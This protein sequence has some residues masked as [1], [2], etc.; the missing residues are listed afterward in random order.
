MTNALA[1]AQGGSLNT[2]FRNRII[3]GDMRIDQRNA[4]AS[5]TLGTVNPQYLLDRWGFQTSQSSKLTVKQNLNSVTPPAGF[6][7]YM[8]V[9]VAATATV[10][11]GD[12]F[13]VR[14]IVEG[15]NAA[16]LNWGTANAKPITI[17]FLVYSSLT[18][19]FGACV[20]NW[21]FNRSY[22]FTYNIAAANTWTQISVTIPGDTSG[23]WPTDNTGGLTLTFGLG[24]GSTFLGTAGVWTASGCLSATGSVNMLSTLGATWYI[25]GVQLEKGSAATPFEFRPYGTELALCQ[26]YFQ[27][28]YQYDTVG[29]TSTFTGASF[30]GAGTQ[31]AALTTGYM[32]EREPF[33]VRMRTS[34]TVTGWDTSGNLGKC[35]RFNPNTANNTNESANFAGTERYVNCTSSSGSSASTLGFHWYCSAEL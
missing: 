3:N 28:S 31:G 30:I 32:E 5:V 14:Q 22:P 29:G 24:I 2:T 21:T 26:R 27:K 6:S 13:S 17:S 35:T 16:D 8:G 15:Y 19:T 1:L 12:Y 7:N 10:G 11:S 9:S 23:T 25:T 33:P 18:G 20:S 34:P 4:G